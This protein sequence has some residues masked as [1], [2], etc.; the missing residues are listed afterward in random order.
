MVH[1]RGRRRARR[2]EEK[3]YSTLYMGDKGE[4][5]RPKEEESLSKKRNRKSKEIEKKRKE[6]ELNLLI[7]SPLVAIWTRPKMD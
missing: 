1:K 2:R 4:S 6:K 3:G 5:P 7:F